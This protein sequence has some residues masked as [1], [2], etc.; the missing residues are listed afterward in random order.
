M[1]Q[2]WGAQ[3][4]TRLGMLVEK[5]TLTVGKCLTATHH[6]LG[7]L[8]LHGGLNTNHMLECRLAKDPNYRHNTLAV[9]CLFSK[10]ILQLRNLAVRTSNLSRCQPGG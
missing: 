4:G 3:E 9:F 5:L 7:Y 1:E 2:H 6:G 8:L 10:G